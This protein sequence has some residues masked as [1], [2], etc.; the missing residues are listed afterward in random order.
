[1]GHVLFS[2]RP[3]APLAWLLIAC[4]AGLPGR[5]ALAGDW[6]IT[7]FMAGQETFTDNVLLTPTN[8]HSDLVTGLSPGVAI[9]GETARFNAILNYSPTIQL[10]ALTPNQIFVD[11][12]LYDNVCAILV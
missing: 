4:V 2:G 6:T 3:S 1:M 5:T 7:P 8:R 11:H 9:S 12:N 10:F